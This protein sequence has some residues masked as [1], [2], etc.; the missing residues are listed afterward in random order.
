MNIISSTKNITV[1][2]DGYGVILRVQGENEHWLAS[3][4]EDENNN[5]L[6]TLPIKV[7]HQ[8]DGVKQAWKSFAEWNLSNEIVKVLDSVISLWENAPNET[9]KVLL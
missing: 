2:P 8:K 7:L 1:T 6:T 3:F 9:K 4:E 5:I